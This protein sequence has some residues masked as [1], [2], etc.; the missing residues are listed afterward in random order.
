MLSKY[1]EKLEYDKIIKNLAQYAKTFIGK[2]YCL[3]LVPFHEKNKVIKALNETNEAVLLRY[4][5]GSI[6]IYEFSEDI[7]VSLK[8]LKSNKTLSIVDVLNIGKILKDREKDIIIRRFGLNGRKPET[9][10]EIAKDLKISRSYVSRIETKAIKK[11][12]SKLKNRA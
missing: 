4:K 11:L 8:T 6:P 1:L 2:K 12:E 7:N 5:K 9:Q 10:N 3:S